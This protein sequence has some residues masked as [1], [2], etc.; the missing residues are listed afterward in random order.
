MAVAF[1]ALLVAGSLAPYM[2]WLIAGTLGLLATY[3]VAR[4]DAGLGWKKYYNALYE[5]RDRY[6]REHPDD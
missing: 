1:V 5:A 3:F 6:L 2:S 4:Y